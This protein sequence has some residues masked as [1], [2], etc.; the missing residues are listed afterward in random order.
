MGK[1]LR[2]RLRTMFVFLTLLAV[3]LGACVMISNQR[4][5]AR[6]PT[7]PRHWPRPIQTVISR[8][9]DAKTDIKVYDLSILLDERALVAIVGHSEIVDSLISDFGLEVTDNQHPYS[10]LLRDSIPSDWKQP[11]LLSCEWYAT[12]GFGTAH[13]EGQDMFLIATDPNTRQ[14][15]ILYTWV[16]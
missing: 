8:F 10:N 16:F 2:F 6:R 11:D 3:L 14:T 7:D 15:I 1:P 12:P 4:Q 5:G 13:I 9:P